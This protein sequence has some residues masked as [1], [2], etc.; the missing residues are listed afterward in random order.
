MTLLP[1]HILTCLSNYGKMYLKISKEDNMKKYDCK[2]WTM[3]DIA[4]AMK[5][6]D[7][8][9]RTIVIPMF[10]RGKR[11]KSDRRDAF[12]DSLLKG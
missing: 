4:H 8:L 5:G 9:D 3:N 10:Q 7:S 1:L 11:W 12:I 6:Q 2:N